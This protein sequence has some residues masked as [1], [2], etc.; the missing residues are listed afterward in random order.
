VEGHG[1]FSGVRRN[2][3]TVCMVHD[4]FVEKIGNFWADG[5]LWQYTS[6]E[7][8][9]I[10]SCFVRISLICSFVWSWG[11]KLRYLFHNC[12]LYF[13]VVIVLEQTG[14]QERR[15]TASMFVV[16]CG[17]NF[18]SHVLQKPCTN[19]LIKSCALIRSVAV[20]AWWRFNRRIRRAELRQPCPHPC[21]LSYER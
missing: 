9:G 2:L 4:S 3:E 14:G 15:T 16:N 13:M 5:A 21:S 1:V 6:L 10:N 8:A 20:K 18:E 11:A 19:I 12:H 7:P 17:C